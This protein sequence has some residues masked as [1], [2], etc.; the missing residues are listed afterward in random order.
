MAQW[1]TEMRTT[2][3][4]MFRYKFLLNSILQEIG[5]GII[6]LNKIVPSSAH[7]STFEL[8]AL[9]AAVVGRGNASAAAGTTVA[10]E[11]SM[12]IH[13]GSTPLVEATDVFQLWNRENDGKSIR[14]WFTMVYIRFTCYVVLHT[15][16]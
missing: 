13:G 4:F 3:K 2:L 12:M 1:I 10:Q 9:P 15:N 16:E 8:P 5:I 6:W 7:G 11:P 14:F